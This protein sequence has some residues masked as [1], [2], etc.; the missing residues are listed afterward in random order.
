MKFI[1]QRI[2]QASII[3]EN[4]KGQEPLHLYLKK[5][6]KRDKKFGSRDRR[7]IAECLY[8]LYRIG[9]ENRHLTIEQRVYFYFF[10]TGNF[11]K[12]FFEENQNE[13]TDK[14]ELPFEE[15]LNFL[16]KKYGLRETFKTQEEIS[17]H[18]DAID[19]RNSFYHEPKVFIRLR[20]NAKEKYVTI[21]DELGGEFIASNCIAFDQKIKLEQHL[22]EPDYVVQ[23]YNSQRTADY[24]PNL[25]KGNTVWD[26][27]AGSGGKS[28]LLLDTYPEVE[29]TATDIR[30]NILSNLIKRFELYNLEAEVIAELNINKEKELAVLGDDAEFDVVMC[31]AP[32]TGSGT[33]AR[34][35]EQFYFFEKKEIDKFQKRQLT[36]L[37]NTSK[38]LKQGGTL[39]Y[40]T[41]SVFAKENED[42]VQ[43]F[44]AEHNNYVQ[45]KAVY[46]GGTR[47]RAD[48]MFVSV[49]TKN[50]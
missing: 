4:Y 19:Y 50:E 40:I 29:L 6:F 23:D 31:D 42:V 13:L 9:R 43:L 47:I 10:L 32:C 18:V 15:K 16:Q 46:L 28:I 33:W 5:Y 36:I 1:K 48:T 21:I 25:I 20:N 27:C 24:F 2:A 12:K 8:A 7:E 34:T 14:S 38:K 44:L 3:F 45:S 41:C 30:A 26:C 22:Q 35:P 11:D 37:T 39:L 17:I 49:L